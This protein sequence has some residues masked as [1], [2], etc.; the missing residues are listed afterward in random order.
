MRKTMFKRKWLF[1][2][3]M[4]S[5]IVSSSAYAAFSF[6][7]KGT[8]SE[9][10]VSPSMAYA[11]IVNQPRNSPSLIKNG[12]NTTT[13]WQLTPAGNQIPLGSFPM[14]GV[15]SPD[16]RF[17]IVSNDG[18]ATQSLQVIDALDQKVLQTLS[19]NAPEA[20]YLGLSFSPDG[21]K[22]YASG[23]G[24]NKIRVFQFTGG[25]LT[26]QNSIPLRDS[27]YP[28]GVIVSPDGKWLYTANNVNNS[29]SRINLLTQK[30][31]S[32]VSVGKRPY[33]PLLSRDGK[34]IYVS[35]WGE[36]SVAVLDADTMKLKELIPVGLHPNA[37]AE[38]PLSGLVYV[39]NSDSDDISIIDPSLL[40]VIETISVLPYPNAP[41]GSQPD[42]LAISSDGTKLYIA[43]AG[44]NDVAVVNLD[45]A[46]KASGARISGLIPTAWYPTG[47]FL[48]KDE[49]KIFVLNAKGLGS[50]PNAK[51]VQWVGSMS[52]GTLSTIKIPAEDQL[53]AYT[54]QVEYNNRLGGSESAS[55]AAEE[56][57]FPIPSHISQTSPIKHIIYVIK[58]NRTYDDILGD[59]GRGNGDPSLVEFGRN[60]TPNHHKLAEQFV[61]L[62]HFY[63]VSDVSADGQNWST[64]GKA[65]D[66]VQKNWH[67]NYS[68]RNRDYD[69]EGGGGGDEPSGVPFT[70]SKE[71][72]LWDLALKSGITFRN[73]G[74]FMQN[75]DTKTKQYYPNDKKT[76][77]FGGNYDPYYGG[78]DLG[79][80]DMTRYQEWEKEFKKYEKNGNLPQLETVY[81]PDDHTAGT[82]PGFRTPQAMMAS[83]DL[84]LGKLVD[85]IS[86]SMYWKDTAIFV[87]EDDAQSGVDHVEAHRVVALAISPYTQTGR[88]DSTPYNTTSMLRT[89]ELILGLKP[90]TQFDASSIPMLGAFTT[91]PVFTPYHV[92]I[93]G[94]P[95]D[96][97]NGEDAPNAEISKSLDF[98]SP[99]SADRDKLN[100]AIWQTTNGA[101]PDPKKHN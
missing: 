46:G 38:N 75:Y 34:T 4:L 71:G 19:Y 39:S 95:I 30:I 69:F 61:T 12:A 100:D 3:G 77:D 22:L 82:F 60:F 16:G 84:A 5:L 66:Y 27:F 49:S 94:Y 58:E 78:W 8:D 63:A 59:L 6:N 85:T 2:F 54:K 23:G 9:E 67:A 17:L 15:L 70:R 56:K 42:A 48:S 18:V 14:G 37:I 43:N 1:I 96:Q 79:L 21:S 29:V 7:L 83:N 101:K 35:N 47:V 33:S 81:L 98:S 73:Y 36:S 87:I 57:E 97:L 20:L 92:E 89:M 50:G 76:T 45:S 25:T 13:G 68:G 65:N 24:N 93:P 99:D 31:E 53:Q 88:V 86:H 72:F 62:D 11:S 80:S 64:A 28:A 55:P 10:A 90:M 51:P 26:E 74:Q 41:T 91:N 44:N 52:T 40:Q 32:T